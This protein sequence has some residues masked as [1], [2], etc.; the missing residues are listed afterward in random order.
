MA[1]RRVAVLFQPD[2]MDLRR[3]ETLR[4][5]ARYAQAAGHWHLALDPYADQREPGR[6]DGIIAAPHRGRARSLAHCPV[7]VVSVTWGLLQESLFRVVENRYAAGRLAARHLAEQGC[8]T[9]AYLGFSRENQSRVEHAKI[10]LECSNSP[11][12]AV[13]RESG[14]GSPAALLRAFRCYVGITPA[15]SRQR[16]GRV[17]PRQRER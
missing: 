16:H 10:Q 12:A 17:P 2:P 4:G 8:R 3:R 1:T 15:D 11:I 13:A 6:C 7:P 14:F 9:F 5:V